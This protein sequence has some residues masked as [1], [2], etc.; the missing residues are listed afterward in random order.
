MHD[1]KFIIIRHHDQIFLIRLFANG[2][3]LLPSADEIKVGI[4]LDLKRDKQKVYGCGKVVLFTDNFQPNTIIIFQ[5][6]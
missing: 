1:H 6:N 4:G 5:S 3:S 2:T